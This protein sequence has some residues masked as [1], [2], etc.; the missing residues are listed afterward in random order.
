MYPSEPFPHF[1]DDYLA[2]LQEAHPTHASLDGV[3][4]HDDL[5]DDLGRTALTIMCGALAGFSR[6]LSQIDAAHLTPTEQVDHAIVAANID[7]R[8]HDVD[9]VRAWDRNPQLYADLLGTSLASQALFDLRARS[10]TRTADGVEAASGASPRAVG[11]GQH[12]G[13][14]GY[15]RQD[16]P[17]NLARRA[18]VHRA[19]PAEGLLPARRPAHPRRPGGHVHR[20]RAAVSHYIQYLEGDL[21]HRGPRRRSGSGANAS[22]TN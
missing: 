15:L 14:T 9:V 17:R 5:L 19:R 11:D 7:G 18:V 4:L 1:V 21:A 10:R 22:S 20:R 3:H 8:I 2:Y 16:R 12:Q 13:G 6:R